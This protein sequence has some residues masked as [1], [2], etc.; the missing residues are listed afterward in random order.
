MLCPPL[1]LCHSFTCVAHI[2]TRYTPAH[3]ILVSATLEYMSAD[4]H[5]SISVLTA[6][7]CVA[8]AA[9]LRQTVCHHAVDC[10]SFASCQL[11]RKR[12]PGLCPATSR[13]PLELDSLHRHSLSLLLLGNVWPS[14]CVG[15]RNV[16]AVATGVNLRNE[17]RITCAQIATRIASTL[18]LQ[19]Q[20]LPLLTVLLPLRRCS[21][22]HR[23]AST[24]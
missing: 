20:P 7:V 14:R 4:A 5:A 2:Y 24:N 23:V 8:V 22:A 18:P 17:T 19:L 3:S 6:A 21:V 11:G 12:L 10:S 15:R 13:L 1:L 9:S 16:A